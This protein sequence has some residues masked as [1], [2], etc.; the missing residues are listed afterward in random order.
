MNQGRARDRVKSSGMHYTPEP[1]ARFL[2]E[3]LFKHLP[4]TTG[5]IRVLDPACGDGALLRAFARCVPARIRKQLVLVGYETDP[6]AISQAGASLKTCH[7]AEVVLLHEDFL[8]ACLDH[9]SPRGAFP[10]ANR[11]A[12]PQFDVV[13]SNPPYVRTQVLGARTTQRLAKEFGLTGRVDLYHAFAIGMTS[14]LR[15]GG[16]L[17]LLT[18]N[19]FFTTNA[20]ESLRRMLRQEYKIHNVF[21]LG[22]TKLFSAAVLPAV[23][24]ATKARLT[25]AA[26]ACR[27]TRV[28]ED[29]KPEKLLTDERSHVLDAI[30]DGAVT[31]RVR[32][33]AGTFLLERGTLPFT[34]DLSATWTLST[35]EY[36]DWL[37]AVEEAQEC[38]VEDIA[39]VRVGIKTTADKVFVR[40]DWDELPPAERPE[41]KLLQPLITH[42]TAGRWKAETG[43][44]RV[45]YPYEMHQSGKVPVSLPDFPQAGKYL[46]RHADALNSRKYLIASG[47]KWYEIWV[48]QVPSQ[49]RE[50]K[51][52]FPDIAE[53]PRF[54]LDMTGAIVQGDCY[55]ISLKAGIEPDWLFVILA[56]CNSSFIEKY[57]DLA[58]HNKL[59]S[60]RRRFMTQY[61]KRFPLPALASRVTRRI[62]ALTKKL[63]AGTGDVASLEQD[64]DRLVWKSFGLVKESPLTSAPGCGRTDE[65]IRERQDFA[66]L[67]K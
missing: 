2:V 40:T 16:A 64:C 6:Q 10:S 54:S 20:G 37:S 38:F 56:V 43:E 24:I 3:Q 5:S 49:W 39:T 22:D 31:G 60:G 45:L 59:Y 67:S 47:R 65:K 61:V 9:S 58:F 7:V 55:W 41:P 36:A 32:T 62:V 28:Y 52:V 35:P 44:H 63:V 1:L 48:P 66:C 18:S 53:S 15:P 51:I 8:A 33:P 14:L 17:G 11:P 50:P 13:I 29:R 57:Y 12:K 19:R 46:S 21:D 23:V 34:S 25:G 27:F 4:R 42:R 26:Q 30:S